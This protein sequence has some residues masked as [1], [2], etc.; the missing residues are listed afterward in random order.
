[1]EHMGT[2]SGPT[3]IFDDVDKG[4]FKADFGSEF[5]VGLTFGFLHAF[6]ACVCCLLLSSGMS[7]CPLCSLA[8]STKSQCLLAQCLLCSAGASPLFCASALCDNT[9]LFCTA[10]CCAFACTW[11]PMPLPFPLPL[12]IF[13]VLYGPVKYQ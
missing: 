9:W 12:N 11:T 13:R 1:M 3:S 2:D 4:D 10:P 8:A 5:P 6:S 7:L